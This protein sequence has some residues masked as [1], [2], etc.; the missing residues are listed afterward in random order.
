M[1]TRYGLRRRSDSRDVWLPVEP[2][3]R[4]TLAKHGY[5][6]A[7][8]VTLVRKCHPRA[9]RAWVPEARLSTPLVDAW[10]EP[11]PRPA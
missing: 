10:G 11:I 4:S 8:A 5:T 7:D 6:E 9:R 1:D 2:A 3:R